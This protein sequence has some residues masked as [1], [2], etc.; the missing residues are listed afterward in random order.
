MG[1]SWMI[2]ALESLEAETGWN[3]VDAERIVGTSAGAVIGALTA[4]GVEPEYL[5]AY[6]SGRAL[7]GFADAEAR[8]V[9][10]AERYQ[11]AGYRLQRALPS[12]GLGSWRLAARTLTRPR[13]HTPATVLAGWLPRGSIS[14]APIAD[15]IEAFVPGH[16][17]EHPSYWA[18]AADYR[19]G[20][21]V[22]FG[23]RDARRARASEAV[24]A[25]CAVPAF[26]HPVS[27][28]GRRYV[29]GGICS[30]SNL[31]L[32]C[33]QRLDLVICLSP[34]SRVGSVAGGSPVDRLIALMR[35][36][37][38]RRLG[39]EARKL[40]EEGTDVLILQPRDE[41]VALM[42]MNLMSG[43]RRLEV[44]DQ[45][46]ATVTRELRRLRERGHL[47]PGAARR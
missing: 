38:G 35:A 19:S 28:A 4:A 3:P 14:T 26:Y 7:D 36:G 15:I 29:D 37:A 24:A 8:A 42:G 16:W 32:L 25:S 2:G 43:R 6:A 22:A 11:G 27:V 45:A 1:A 40:R 12:L 13:R 21:R 10:A 17:P 33:A 23:R 30:P 44:M 18:I 5:S 34:M 20:E 31:D 41:D 39:R 47:L 46:R 9:S